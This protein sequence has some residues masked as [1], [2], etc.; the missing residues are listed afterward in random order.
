MP[1]YCFSCE[2]GFSDEL[3]FKLSV[4]RPRSVRCGICGKR[5]RRDMG[6]EGRTNR[7][8]FQTRFDMGL[9]CVVSSAADIDRI[10]KKKGLVVAGI[11]R[12]SFDPPDTDPA[13]DDA[14]GDDD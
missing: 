1:I 8:S 2:C 10:C 11:D 5:A 7:G 13:M 9:G 12:G 4:K 6:A 3:Y 14:F